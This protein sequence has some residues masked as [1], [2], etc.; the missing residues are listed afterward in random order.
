MGNRPARRVPLRLRV[1]ALLALLAGL[2][3]ANTGLTLASGAH[4]NGLQRAENRLDQTALAAQRLQR[5]LEGQVVEVRGFALSGDQ[6][7]L[8]GYADQRIE[9][10]LLVVRLRD[11]LRG[12]NVLLQ[13]LDELK[14]AILAWRVRVAD[15]LIE[16]TL[17]DVGTPGSQIRNDEPL[18]QNVRERATALSR[19]IGERLGAIGVTVEQARDRLYQ[20][21]LI[22]A[23]L[24]LLL[25][26][27]S[28]WGL[29]RWIT[30]PIAQLT[31]QVRRVAAGML[32]EPVFGSGPV[33]FEQL[34][35][36]VERMRRRIVEDLEE[37]KRAIEALE[38]NAPLVASLR[39]QLSASSA[40]SL[41]VG[42]KIVG[43]L[44]PAHGVLA[45]DWYD[46]IRLDDEHVAL[47]VVDVCGH[48]P[49]AG[50]RALWLK[51][52]LVPALVM[53]L[54]PGEALSWVAGQMGDTGEWFATC[55]VVEING[56]TGHCRYANA[57][58]PPP[59]LIGGDGVQELHA[60]GPIFG[61]LPGQH[62]CSADASLSRHPTLVVY[63]DGITETRNAA[64]DEFGDERLIGCIHRNGDD[65][66]SLLA[67]GVMRSV[68]AFGNE[69][70][71]D[72]ATLAVVTFETATANVRP[73]PA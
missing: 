61:A 36:D 14:V 25:V 27:G 57:G 17:E 71:K 40:S 44:E 30:L 1:F 32:Q 33:E 15:R 26:A 53:R 68:H 10:Q 58:H 45:G 37:T 42:L 19:G 67:D 73:A 51:H 34:G 11:L 62:W 49:L 43:R 55:V 69:R 5:S 7:F 65:D 31:R 22:S 70:L 23:A 63:T 4:L 59:L 24:A 6:S 41:P 18:F 21:L 38:Q 8:R 2:V 66:P 47:I 9:E 16:G 29:R 13:R 35:N 46:V 54:E 50:L 60:T 3:V 28:T 20:Q 12:R 56:I 72:D 52:L 48:G 39:S 64:G